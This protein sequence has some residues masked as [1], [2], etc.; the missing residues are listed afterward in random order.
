MLFNEI[1]TLYILKRCHVLYINVN[2][3]EAFYSFRFRKK[4]GLSI[5]VDINDKLDVI[6]PRRGRDA[7]EELFFFKLYLV[8]K[9]SFGECS[10][11]RGRRI[12]TCSDPNVE[13]KY[14]FY[15]QEISPSPFGLEFQPNSD[16]Y[17]ICKLN[18]DAC[19]TIQL[20]YT[21]LV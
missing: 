13:K 10:V 19:D 15:F 11:A 18:T 17:I 20:F 2:V 5:D 6:C 7:G 1:G 21:N 3:N 12:L 9:E 4:N 8:E 16:Y 14:T